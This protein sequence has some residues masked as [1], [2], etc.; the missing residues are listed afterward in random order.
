MERAMAK[1]HNFSTLGTKRSRPGSAFAVVA[2]V[3]ASLIIVGAASVVSLGEFSTAALGDA[4]ATTH[5]R[6]LVGAT[7]SM[8]VGDDP[9]KADRER[10]FDYFPD[11]YHNQATE[12]AEP[13][14]TF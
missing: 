3:A 10:G 1:I 13:I 6:T 8:P 7:K 9:A 12:P 5:A 14:A 11:R 4:N 2:V